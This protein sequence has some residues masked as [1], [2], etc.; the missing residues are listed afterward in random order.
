MTAKR[1]GAAGVG[2]G[3]FGSGSCFGQKGGPRALQR[4]RS[5]RGTAAAGHLSSDRDEGGISGANVPEL[6]AAPLLNTGVPCR[7]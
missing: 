2:F 5:R 3:G 7:C 1:L 6:L 4:R